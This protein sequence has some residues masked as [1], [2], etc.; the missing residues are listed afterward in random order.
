M[1]GGEVADV[2]VGEE[3]LASSGAEFE[4]LAG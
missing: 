2:A 1:D 4:V 3:V